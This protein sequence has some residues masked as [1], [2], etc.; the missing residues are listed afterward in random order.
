[1]NIINQLN[2]IAAS[3][4]ISDNHND[5]EINSII[6]YGKPPP[7]SISKYRTSDLFERA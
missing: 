6:H 1:M 3:D 2:S 4:V 5:C 7:K